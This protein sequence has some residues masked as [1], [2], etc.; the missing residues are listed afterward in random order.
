MYLHE[1]IVLALNRTL[2]DSFQELIVKSHTSLTDITAL[3]SLFS[4]YPNSISIPIISHSLQIINFLDF[5]NLS[6]SSSSEAL[7]LS[8]EIPKTPLSQA[9]SQVL[10]IIIYYFII[11]ILLLLLH[12]RCMQSRSMTPALM[13][14]F[15]SVS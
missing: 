7:D 6:F 11:I 3:I 13:R 2:Y 10:Y 8:S 1:A 12:L 9:P 15:T 14:T 4:L 5:Y